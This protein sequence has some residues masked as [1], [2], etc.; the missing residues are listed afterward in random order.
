MKFNIYAWAVYAFAIVSLSSC[1]KKLEGSGNIISE[2]RS[3]NLFSGVQN[4]GSFKVILVNRPQY[5]LTLQGEDNILP[6]IETSVIN[7]ILRI[8]YRR[9][10][11][12]TSHG[13]II[14]TVAAPGINQLIIRGS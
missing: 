5:A 10:N 8:G 11:V 4:E 7:G 14:V 1:T 9:N 6:E 12:N 2:D 13:E 3:I